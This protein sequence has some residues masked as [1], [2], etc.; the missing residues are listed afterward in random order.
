MRERIEVTVNG[1][2]GVPTPV[3]QEDGGKGKI[4]QI[5]IE[6]LDLGYLVNVGCKR[7]AIQTAEDLLEK[8]KTYILAPDETEKKYSKGELFS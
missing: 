4:Y 5:I 6:Q 8:L 1:S 2:M 3:N 7:F